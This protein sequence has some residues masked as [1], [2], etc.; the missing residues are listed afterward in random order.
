M[1]FRVDIRLC[2][3]VTSNIDTTY[4]WPDDSLKLEEEPILV[5]ALDNGN[6]FVEEGRYQVI[7]ALLRGQSFIEVE[8][9]DAHVAEEEAR[10]VKEAVARHIAK[11]A[12]LSPTT[13]AV[14]H[15]GVTSR[16]TAF[17]ND[18]PVKGM[19][20][21]NALILKDG[22]IVRGEIDLTFI[23]PTLKSAC[24]RNYWHEA[25]DCGEHM[26]DRC[27]GLPK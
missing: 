22:S 21:Y 6:Y 12:G 9:Y 4:L 27:T 19:P 7:R 16:G 18:A 11:S 14:W 10:E 13:R 24:G 5:K 26:E 25:H 23:P 8:W 3:Y 15:S 17:F 1:T 2:R 20:P